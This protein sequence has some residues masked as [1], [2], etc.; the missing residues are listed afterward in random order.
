MCDLPA[1]AGQF[2]SLTF[3]LTRAGPLPFKSENGEP[4]GDAAFLETLRALAPSERAL[5]KAALTAQDLR[6]LTLREGDV[7]KVRGQRTVNKPMHH[8]LHR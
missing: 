3:L 8:S 6:K 4:G 5:A 2:R 7:A 1:R